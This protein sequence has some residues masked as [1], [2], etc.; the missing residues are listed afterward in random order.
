MGTFNPHSLSSQDDNDSSTSHPGATSNE[1]QA[2]I[3]DEDSNASDQIT[4]FN[5]TSRT[6][7]SGQ[8]QEKSSAGVGT[9]RTEGQ[10]SEPHE[11]PA[12]KSCPTGS[13]NTEQ[14][15]DQG[16]VAD[17]SCT[18]TEEPGS[19]I[20][21][22][23][24]MEEQ[25]PKDG[26]HTDAATEATLRRG[27]R[28]RKPTKHADDSIVKPVRRKGT[29]QVCIDK[30]SDPPASSKKRKANASSHDMAGRKKARA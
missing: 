20:D 3:E 9:C 22:N 14:S 12:D 13:G 8:P 11:P 27:Q 29:K 21:I 6:H 25:L 30:S 23:T 10:L 2:T 18:S 26:V 5:Q 1:S 19:P 15:L 16:S 24:S 17:K 28:A 4:L 7:Q